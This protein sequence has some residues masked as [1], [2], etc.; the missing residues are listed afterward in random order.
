[1]PY[2]QW[3]GG[4]QGLRLITLGKH[5][6]A[7]NLTTETLSM[8]LKSHIF[9]HQSDYMVGRLR[10][11][12]KDKEV[13]LKGR[14]ASGGLRLEDTHTSILFAFHR[15]ALSVTQVLNISREHAKAQSQVWRPSSWVR[16]DIPFLHYCGPQSS[17]PYQRAVEQSRKVKFRTPIAVFNSQ[18]YPHQWSN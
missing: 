17:C 4:V 12:T 5:T 6:L 3:Q 2:Y 14:A 9:W 10:R 1:M 13:Q 7:T 16:R 18:E 8:Y 11:V 15:V